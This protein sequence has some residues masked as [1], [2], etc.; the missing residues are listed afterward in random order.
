MRVVVLGAAGQLGVD[1]VREALKRRHR[2]L[3][4]TKR[5]LDIT[6]TR[7]VTAR[8]GQLRPDAVLNAA[9]YNDVDRAE[10]EH[11]RAMGV[12]AYGARNVA[13]ASA[14][15]GAVLVHYSTDMVFRGDGNTPY[16]ELDK[17]DPACKYGV[18][19]LTG[20]T[21]VRMCCPAHYVLRVAAL[22]GPPGRFTRR[23]NF[24]ETVLRR[25]REG[26]SLRVVADRVVSPTFGPALAARSLDILETEPPRGIYHLAGGVAVSWHAFAV[27]LARA[28]GAP[29]SAVTPIPAVEYPTVAPR[30]AYSALSNGRIEDVGIRPMPALDDSVRQYLERRSAERPDPLGALS[31]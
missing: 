7:A 20:E 16:T 30:P 26:A 29:A 31:L 14:L 9:A 22:F 10:R 18:S 1:L 6:D 2:V 12:N 11:D 8:I 24:A 17:P 25:C 13:I 5:D 28:A 4:L 15:V 27:R 3:A 23:G 21:I 19:K